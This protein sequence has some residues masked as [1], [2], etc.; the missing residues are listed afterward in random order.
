MASAVRRRESAIAVGLDP[1]P[2]RLWRG[3]VAVPSGTDPGRAAASAVADH[4]RRV[5]DATAPACVAVKLQSASFERLGP[6]GLRALRD[7]AEHARQ[8][9]LLV[10]LDAKR[11]DIDVSA[12]AY[13][14]A[15]FSGVET[16]W[17]PV[18]GVAADAVT[19]AP[20]MGRDSVVPFIDAGRPTG[21]GVF[22][23]VRTSNPGAAD[24]Q[25]H[26]MQDG[27]PVWAR[28]ARM[29]AALGEASVAGADAVSDVGAVVGATAPERLRRL[30]E[31][32]PATPFL[33]PG[34]GAQGGRVEDLAPAFA[35]GP[36]SAI[37]TASRSV[38][39]ADD[40]AEDPAPAARRAAEELRALA[41]AL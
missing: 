18:P 11:G 34:V 7:V 40:G 16:P 33:L 29:V 38:V 35:P 17:G 21:G 20:Y 37:V 9:D 15:A 39:G 10:L 13:A 4:C 6:D 41:A 36:G 22:V 28:V 3:G 23:L 5:L 12:A 24:L 31:L 8:L 32:M 2:A 26:A 19:V 27:E 25:E 30:R 14:A 1:D